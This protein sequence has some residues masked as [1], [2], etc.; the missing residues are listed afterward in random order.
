MDIDAI[1]EELGRK[2]FL[3]GV[4]YDDNRYDK[5]KDLQNY[6]AWKVGYKKEEHAYTKKMGNVKC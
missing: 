2:D 3:N 4:R 6:M 1:A 5:F